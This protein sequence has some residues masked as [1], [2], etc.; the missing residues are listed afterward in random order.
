MNE[1]PEQSGLFPY[2]DEKEMD[3]IMIKQAINQKLTVGTITLLLFLLSG[4]W[5][6]GFLLES[7]QMAA[8]LVISIGF[9]LFLIKQRLQGSAELYLLAAFFV[10]YA[11]SLTYGD[12]HHEALTG[13]LR[14]V[15]LIPLLLFVQSAEQQVMNRIWTVWTWVVGFSVPIAIISNRFVDGRLAG[16]ID[17]ANSYAVVLLVGLIMAIAMSVVQP[18]FIPWMQIPIF[19]C[20][21]G[22]YMTQSRTV[23]V[24]ML[25]VVP[26]LWFILRRD[27][28][29]LWLHSCISNV[30]GIG[31][32]AAYSWTP[33]LCIPAA[34]LFGLVLRFPLNR[35]TISSRSIKLV[36][37]CAIPVLAVVLIWMGPGM[38]ERWST[39]TSRTGEGATRLVYYRDAWSLVLDSP[40]WGCGAGAWSN[41]QYAYRSSDYFTAYV[42]S[43]PLQVMMEVGIIGFMLLAAACIWP[44]VRGL[45][46]ARSLES[47]EAKLYVIRA[48]AGGVLLLHSL[49]DFSLSFPYILG[50]F[51]ILVAVPAT[52]QRADSATTSKHRHLIFK[53]T[54]IL[55]A[56][57]TFVLS[58]MLLVS[59]RLQ[60]SAAQA[61]SEAR[62]AD[63]VQLLDRSADYAIWPDRI[64]DRKARMYLLEYDATHDRRYLEV[65]QQDNDRALAIYPN[66]IGYEKL[67]S[68]IY[69]RLG[70]KD[71]AVQLLSELVD[72]NHFMDQWHEDL[73]Q[74]QAQMK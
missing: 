25:T 22:I 72:Q 21:A 55:V 23:L 66:H 51:F 73:K 33:L 67:R 59:D 3:H 38:A 42:H 71:K 19:L 34:I 30:L 6:H 11:I 48:L 28:A 5:F 69:W 20:A 7:E 35:I 37:V 70:N 53:S 39:F 15:M 49:V 4:P 31:A 52:S 2:T 17:Y 60:Q 29:V 24:L 45:L 50:L 44:I 65:A 1:G 26:V 8:V 14:A 63:A 43:G 32:A 16:Y 68:D 41:L 64:Y 13:L 27:M 57:G 56:A 36:L 18:S 47:T 58:T 46:A 9:I 74:K 40:I 12:D 54:A 62:K 10:L 61:Y